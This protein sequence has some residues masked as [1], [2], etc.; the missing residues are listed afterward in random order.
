MVSEPIIFVVKGTNTCGKSNTV[1]F[2]IYVKKDV[3][4]PCF[5]LDAVF[6]VG[7]MTCEGHALEKIH[8]FLFPKLGN[9]WRQKSKSSSQNTNYEAHNFEITSLKKSKWKMRYVH[10]R[11]SYVIM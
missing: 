9:I 11:S 3:H 10:C 2:N 1:Q 8:Y 5:V 6:E 7:K 4:S